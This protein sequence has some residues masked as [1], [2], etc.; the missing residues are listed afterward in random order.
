MED[1]VENGDVKK[2]D[3]EEQSYVIISLRHDF[4]LVDYDSD[5]NPQPMSPENLPDNAYIGRAMIS[6]VHFPETTS[7]GKNCFKSCRR[8]STADMPLL[9]NAGDGA[10]QD[11]V[12][13]TE[14]PENLETVGNNTF[15][16]CSSVAEVSLGKLKS[17]G[18]SG[19][20][21]CHS[22]NSVYIPECT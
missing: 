10:F 16:G 6:E 3:N 17:I 12:S 7:V 20:R 18:D 5:G 19:F 11:C 21:G 22:L 9:K 4:D 8:M 14:L 13:L 15:N 1:V 2:R